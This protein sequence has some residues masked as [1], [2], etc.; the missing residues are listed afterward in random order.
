MGESL[1]EIDVNGIKTFSGHQAGLQV[2]S[3][4]GIPFIPTK[5]SPHNA[6]DGNE[7]GRLFGL[8]TSDRDG[9]GYP[10]MGIQ[11]AIP[12]TYNEAVRGTNGWPFVN[13]AFSEKGV[14]WTMGELVCRRFNGN[15]KIRDIQL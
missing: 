15:F 2:T 9:F 1:V 11:V 3:L 8:D 7:I 5:D 14:Y 12:T 10:R 6:T 4:Y 13:G